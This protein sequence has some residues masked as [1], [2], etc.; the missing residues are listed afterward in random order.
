MEPPA[1]PARRRSNPSRTV[2]SKSHSIPRNQTAHNMRK[3][4]TLRT[5][6]LKIPKTSRNRPKDTAKVTQRNKNVALTRRLLTSCPPAQR[7]CTVDIDLSPKDVAAQTSLHP[8]HTS[9]T[10]ASGTLSGIMRRSCH[11]ETLGSRKPLGILWLTPKRSP[12][13]VPPDRTQAKPSSR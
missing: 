12:L 6:E 8:S 7:F 4:E 3:V 1:R 2:G 13:G 5:G 11:F 10:A 9:P